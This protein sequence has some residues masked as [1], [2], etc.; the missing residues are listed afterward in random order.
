MRHNCLPGQS[1]GIYALNAG[2]SDRAEPSES[3]WRSSGIAVINLNFGSP[4]V[5]VWGE[6]IPVP[7]TAGGGLDDI[8]ES[9]GGQSVRT[10]KSLTDS[11]AH[12]CL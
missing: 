11:I 12:P 6:L 2:M 10:R 5:P 1:L 3:L 4:P 9:S 7:R 8:M